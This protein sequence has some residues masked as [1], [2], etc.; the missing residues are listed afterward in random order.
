MN[1]TK[2]EFYQKYL[3]NKLFPISDEKAARELAKELNYEVIKFTRN[4]VEYVTILPSHLS[5]YNIMDTIWNSKESEES[6]FTIMGIY[7]TQ[8]NNN[9]NMEISSVIKAG[10]LVLTDNG[11]NIV[12]NCGGGFWIPSEDLDDVIE[13]RRPKTLTVNLTEEEF[14][15]ATVVWSKKKTLFLGVS[16]EADQELVD[17]CR[18]YYS[19][20]Y[21]VI[22][23]N[24]NITE[25]DNNQNVINADEHVIIPPRDFDV[26]HLVGLGLYNQWSVRKNAKKSSS[27]CYCDTVSDFTKMI[28]L[29]TNDYKQYAVVVF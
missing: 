26:T 8:V 24:P 13:V 25:Y 23:W 11:I 10:D 1:M 28:P 14:D 4:G 7:K 18:K 5:V 20:D 15:K 6:M 3:D 19:E 9:M 29:K 12:L 27:I 16:Y 22:E 2:V 21:D 17:S